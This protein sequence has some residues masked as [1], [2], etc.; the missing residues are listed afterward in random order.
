MNRT[1]KRLVVV[2]LAG[3]LVLL[4]LHV[5]LLDGIDGWFFSKLAVGGEHTRYASGYTDSA[6]RSVRVGMSK[7]EVLGLLGVPLNTWFLDPERLEVWAYTLSPSDSSYRIRV[8]HFREGL[9]VHKVS[10]FYVD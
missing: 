3:L 9:V 4:A 10:E 6:F 7:D 8:V 5:Y 2:G 1:V